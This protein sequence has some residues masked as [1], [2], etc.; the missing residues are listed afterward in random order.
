MYTLTLED[1]QNSPTLQSYGAI[2]G[3][4]INDENG[5]VRVFSQEEDFVGDTGEVLTQ[6]TITS[7]PTL[8][9]LNAQVGD[10]VIDN[11]LISL[12]HSHSFYYIFYEDL[13]FE[14]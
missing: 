10:R 13:S 3:D 11:L 12:I 9:K 1:I 7:S 6:Q 14:L 8:Q 5:L 4:Q 2:P